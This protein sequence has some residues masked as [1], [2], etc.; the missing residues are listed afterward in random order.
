LLFI[1][2]YLG[3]WPLTF[4]LKGQLMGYHV[5]PFA[6]VALIVFSSIYLFIR[7]EIFLIIFLLLLFFGLLAAKNKL[8]TFSS[9]TGSGT[10]SW[11]FN[12]QLAQSVFK[13]AP[14]EFGYGP[15]Y[16]MVFTNKEYP[17]ISALANTKKRITYVIMAPT[18][19]GVNNN[20]EWWIKNKV[21]INKV[22]ESVISYA[23]GFEI[24]KFVLTDQE[25]KVP[26]DPNL[27]NGLFFR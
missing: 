11:K 13:S 24:E 21:R 12:H 2:F 8:D 26:S 9:L 3:Y 17:N 5:L 7:K 23:N 15:R 22:P 16:A 14:S 4:Y 27:L 25:I 20:R 18:E 10:G 19:G 1:Y 6:P